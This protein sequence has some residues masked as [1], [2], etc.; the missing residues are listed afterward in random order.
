MLIDKEY[1]N[2]TYQQI[3]EALLHENI[4]SRPIWK[5]MHLQPVFQHN[6]FITVDKDTDVGGDIF[7]RGLCRPSDIKITEA[8]ST[9]AGMDADDILNADLPVAYGDAQFRQRVLERTNGER[10]PVGLVLSG[11]SPVFSP[12]SRG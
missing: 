3:M 1:T 7:S 8:V 6:D 12:L 4:V 11:G 5:P 10:S 2:V 9:L